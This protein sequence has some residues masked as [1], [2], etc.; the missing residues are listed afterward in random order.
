MN[1][2][3]VIVSL[4]CTFSSIQAAS[5]SNSRRST[6]LD[7]EK[8]IAKKDLSDEISSP[9][10][11]FARPVTSLEPVS[12]LESTVKFIITIKCSEEVIQITLNKPIKPKLLYTNLSSEKQFEWT[13]ERVF[14]LYRGE[15]MIDPLDEEEFDQDCSLSLVFSDLSELCDEYENLKAFVEHNHHSLKKYIDSPEYYENYFFVY[16]VVRRN[17][18]VLCFTPHKIKNDYFIL[19]NAVKNDPEAIQAVPTNMMTKEIFLI[20]YRK[21]PLIIDQILIKAEF[22]SEI[23]IDLIKE[24]SNQ[25]S[26]IIPS[27]SMIQQICSNAVKHCELLLKH[28]PKELQTQE[29][30]SIATNVC[31]L[32]VKHCSLQ[33]QNVPKELRTQEVCSMAVSKNGLALECLPLNERLTYLCKL[34]VGQNFKALRF[35]PDESM[36]KDICLDAVQ[37]SGSAL[38]YVPYYLRK[39]NLCSLCVE[40]DGL[41]LEFVPSEHISRPLIALAVTQ[42]GIALQHVPMQMRELDICELA[43]RNDYKAIEWIPSKHRKKEICLTAIRN[44]PCL[45]NQVPVDILDRDIYKEAV[46]R[47]LPRKLLIPTHLQAKVDQ[48]NST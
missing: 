18:Q 39:P 42:N 48:F 44:D 31:S 43:F 40:K 10:K 41:S 2:S 36:S 6:S 38:R 45:F 47:V 7:S 3:A 35:V 23:L 24:D 20:A 46:N 9:K 29:V 13:D 5:K 14:K 19:L 34:A 27:E 22:S 37:Q 33:L 15:E 26:S 8:R 12:D 21:K 16:F 32:A 25:L 11:K 4:T 30:L 28:V 1:L 17:W